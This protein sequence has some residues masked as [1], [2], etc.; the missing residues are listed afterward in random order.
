M[1]YEAHCTGSNRTRKYSAILHSL[2]ECCGVAAPDKRK[3]HDIGLNS[4]KLDLC[5]VGQSNS[6]TED[7]SVCLVFDQPAGHLIERYKPCRSQNTGLAHSPAHGLA[8]VAC[9][10]HGLI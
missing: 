5:G 10:A 6:L 4:L 7:S 2:Y 3:Y 8:N 9:A 1:G